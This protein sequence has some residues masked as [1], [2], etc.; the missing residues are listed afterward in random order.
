VHR[1]LHASWRARLSSL[2]DSSSSPS[3]ASLAVRPSPA[4]RPTPAFSAILLHRPTVQTITPAGY[5]DH[6]LSCQLAEA[7]TLNFT[8]SPEVARQTGTAAG[9]PLKRLTLE[10]GG[11]SLASL[12]GTALG[13]EIPPV[14]VISTTYPQQGGGTGTELTIDPAKYS[15][16]FLDNK[17]PAYEAG[18]LAAEQRPL[19]LAALT[20]TSGTPAWKTIPSW[21]M[22][23]TQDMVTNPDR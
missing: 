14:P 5:P 17:L 10:P 6:G 12:N 4:G 20:E 16:V 19:S 22:V 1:F 15:Y 9:G 23:A 21:Y 7:S 13:K 3:I 18:A 8:G 2:R 11:D